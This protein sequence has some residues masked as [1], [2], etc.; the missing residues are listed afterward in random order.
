[1]GKTGNHFGMG[2][3]LI[4]LAKVALAEGQLEQAASLFGTAELQIN[5]RVD[6]HPDMEPFELLDYACIVESV[7]T[8]LGAK[9][10]TAAWDKG[11]SMTPE[12]VL[13]NLGSMPLPE[14]AP[15]GHPSTPVETV[16]NHAGLTR[17]EMK[18]LCLLAREGLT[19]AQIAEQ[20]VISI[21]TVRS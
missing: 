4:G 3:N 7:R 17:S 20:L 18:V 12:Q 21:V 16:P 9:A 8:Q 1:A 2:R 19:D 5:P 14:S 10:F 13:A 11:Q 15:G 6:F